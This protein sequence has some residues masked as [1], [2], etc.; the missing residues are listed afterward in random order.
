MG[1]YARWDAF[2]S[3]RVKKRVGLGFYFNNAHDIDK[4]VIL[5]CVQWYISTAT[6]P[7]SGG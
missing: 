3:S 5:G 2:L 1:K 7:F 6:K 4:I